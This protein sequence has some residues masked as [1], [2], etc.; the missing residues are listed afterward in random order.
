MLV[1]LLNIA[2]KAEKSLVKWLEKYALILLRMAI[3]IIY[4]WFGALKF[5]PEVSPAETLALDT[6]RILSL[7]M[8]ADQVSIVMLAVWECLIGIALIFNIKL[9]TTLVLLLLHMAG[10][11][12]PFVLF[13]EMTFGGEPYTF[14]LFGQYIMKNVVIITAALVVFAVGRKGK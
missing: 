14:T 3:G 13:P 1:Y 4:L 6:I 11:L 2:D 7:G 8:L 5:F 12:T 10:T 9:R